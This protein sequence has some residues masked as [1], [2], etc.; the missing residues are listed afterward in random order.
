[1]SAHEA[2]SDDLKIMSAHEAAGDG[3]LTI[4]SAYEVLYT[5]KYLAVMN[6]NKFIVCLSTEYKLFKQTFAY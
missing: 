2:A 1:M 6:H 4:I 3:L 5:V